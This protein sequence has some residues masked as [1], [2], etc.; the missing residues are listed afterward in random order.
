[1]T[2]VDKNCVGYV[3]DTKVFQN[4]LNA[5]SKDS[6]FLYRI[7]EL[8]LQLIEFYVQSLHRSCYFALTSN[9]TLRSS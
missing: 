3:F 1:M 4:H 7:Q 9:T 5:S 8:T 2:F 6:I